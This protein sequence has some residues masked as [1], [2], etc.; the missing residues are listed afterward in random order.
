LPA[1]S[2]IVNSRRSLRSAAT[3][4]LKLPSAFGVNVVSAFVR[5]LRTRTTPPGSAVPCEPVMSE[6]P[7]SFGMLA[8]MV[9][10]GGA[11]GGVTSTVVK[12]DSNEAASAWPAVSLMT[13]VTT[14]E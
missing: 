5:R 3:V 13:G 4:P 1:A 7:A 10:A 14:S 2:R 11:A 8:T 12:W 6:L 9:P